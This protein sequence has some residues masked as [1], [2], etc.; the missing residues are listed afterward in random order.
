M[1]VEFVTFF[2]GG[3]KFSVEGTLEALYENIHLNITDNRDHRAY[4]VHCMSMCIYS[5][6]FGLVVDISSCH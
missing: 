5:T 1:C 4:L 6:W 2:A 3:K